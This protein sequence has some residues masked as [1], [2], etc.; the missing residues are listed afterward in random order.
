MSILINRKVNEFQEILGQ[1]FPSFPS[2][3]AHLKNNQRVPSDSCLKS[4]NPFI[5]AHGL[6]H[7]GGQ[8]LTY[9][10]TEVPSSPAQQAFTCFT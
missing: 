9:Y 8:I 1:V 3:L 10:S 5:D 6:I 4:L 2:K 7:V